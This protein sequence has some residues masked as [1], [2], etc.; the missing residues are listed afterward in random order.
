[1]SRYPSADFDLAFV[2][3]DLVPAAQVARTLREA[4]GPL[5]EDLWLF[6]V[7]R[8]SQLGDGRRSLAYRLR[9][10]AIDHTLTEEELGE[11]RQRAIAAVRASTGATLRG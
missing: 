4:T 2:V 7:F 1:V 11:L 3:D 10:T 5:L 6:D 8:G 9:V